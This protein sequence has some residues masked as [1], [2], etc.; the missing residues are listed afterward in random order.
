MWSPIA[1]FQTENVHVF[2]YV[3]GM[4]LRLL[5]NQIIRNFQDITFS[6]NGQCRKTAEHQ[7][8]PP[9][10]I[11]SFLMSLLHADFSFNAFMLILNT[12]DKKKIEKNEYVNK[13]H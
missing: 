7:P 4:G 5:Y 11:S 9:I 1:L 6:G 3:M 10:P 13:N 12:D 2:V 8:Q